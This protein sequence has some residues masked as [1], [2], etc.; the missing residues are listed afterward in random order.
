MATQRWDPCRELQSARETMRQLVRQSVFP[1]LRGA[2][3]VDVADAGDRYILHASLAGVRPEDVE[4]TVQG[5]EI[6]IRAQAGT[7]P[8]GPNRRWI[9]RERPSGTISRSIALLAAVD[10]EK[11]S[12]RFERGMLILT[13]PKA[14]PAAARR[15]RL[16]EAPDAEHTPTDRGVPVTTPAG[17]AMPSA[18]PSE[19]LAGENGKPK[20]AVTQSS[21]ESFPASDP[22]SWTSERT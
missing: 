14:D 4:V 10:S 12:A 19:A 16:G 8:D 18:M 6:T 7:P 2:I 5:N 22:P 17:S 9:L 13:L 15:I 1:G 3:P 20:D 11:A 21:E